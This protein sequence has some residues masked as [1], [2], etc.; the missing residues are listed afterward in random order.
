M[1]RRRNPAGAWVVYI[2]SGARGAL[3]TGIT[4]CI[5]RR[6]AEHAAGRRAARWFRFG[7]PGKLRYLEPAADRPG[8]LRR[9]AAIKRLSRAQKLKLIAEHPRP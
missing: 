3:Y 6:L 1:S 7:A 9:E 4:T 2:V 8:A 5:E